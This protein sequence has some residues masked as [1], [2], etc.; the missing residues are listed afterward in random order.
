M[1]TFKPNCDDNC[2]DSESID[3]FDR[4]NDRDNDDISPFNR[5]IVRFVDGDASVRLDDDDDGGVV[6]FEEEKCRILQG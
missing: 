2:F 6:K 1:T 3:D 5:E 4:R